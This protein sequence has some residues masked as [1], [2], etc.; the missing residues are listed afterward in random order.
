MAVFTDRDVRRAQTARSLAAGPAREGGRG[1]LNT[2]L[3]PVGIVPPGRGERRS[4][5]AATLLSGALPLRHCIVVADVVPAPSGWSSDAITA[6]A[7][8][9]GDRRRDVVVWDLAG[10]TT[11]GA[12]PHA[13]RLAADADRLLAADLELAPPTLSAYLERTARGVETLPADP[14]F[15]TR[16][17]EAVL[18]VLTHHRQ[19]VMLHARRG[20]PQWLWSLSRSTVVV[21]PVPHREES[22]ADLAATIDDLR[23]AGLGEVVDRV[24]VVNCTIGGAN[25]RSDTIEMRRRLGELGVRTVLDVPYARPPRIGSGRGGSERSDT[26]RAWLHASAVIARTRPRPESPTVRSGGGS[27]LLGSAAVP[28]SDPS[29]LDPRPD[30]TFEV[31]TATLRAHVGS[32]S[33]ERRRR[34]RMGPRSAAAGVLL[35]VAAMGAAV[36]IGQP[37]AADR[38][39][40][41][42][43]A[44]TQPVS[45]ARDEAVVDSSPSAPDVIAAYDDF[46]Y[47]DRDAVGAAGLWELPAVPEPE[48]AARIADLQRVIDAVDPR[49]RHRISVTDTGD[50]TVFD[51]VLTLTTA[52]GSDHR[53]HQQFTMRETPDGMRIVN[54]ID[55][56]TQCP[57]P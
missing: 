34:R 20:D 51:A 49:I 43:A 44:G 18:S 36:V 19:I 2:V 38:V 10:G 45:V 35:V 31:T 27:D 37:V 32:G 8:A 21:I 4:R 48:S 14:S 6:V 13:G 7:E 46:Y 41:T 52:D 39:A 42:A 22:M 24:V 47:R 29:L 23:S 1:L 53:Y 15:R 55:C 25:P 56:E 11:V 57:A 50:P 28:P 30:P 12:G 5:N 33:T 3:G 54:K 26:D 16:D 40:V 17:A 9:I